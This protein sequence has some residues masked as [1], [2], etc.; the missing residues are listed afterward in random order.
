M[1]CGACAGV[2]RSGAAS[3]TPATARRVQVCA[4]C[5]S[6]AILVSVCVSSTMLAG[7]HAG[8]LGGT[9][10][11]ARG[12][13]AGASGGWALTGIGAVAWAGVGGRP[14]GNETLAKA[15]GGSYCCWM[16]VVGFTVL[17]TG[18]R[19]G[20]SK[21]VSWRWSTRYGVMPLRG[22]RQR[23]GCGCAAA[24]SAAVRIGCGVVGIARIGLAPSKLWE[25]R[26]DGACLELPALR[27][28]RSLGWLRRG[29]RCVRRLVGL[30]SSPAGTIGGQSSA[31]CACEG[32]QPA[33]DAE[34]RPEPAATP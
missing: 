6:L 29:L 13:G 14:S 25:L 17:G 22:A 20:G 10:A 3:G 16:G 34:L 9:R 31:L 5:A 23:S 26:D 18:L 4:R 7:G 11:M 28:L 21:V 19:S 2:A 33:A 32:A 15:A 27:S 30:V 12:G 8:G 24:G 1:G